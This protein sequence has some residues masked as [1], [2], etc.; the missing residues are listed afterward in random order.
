[1]MLTERGR[2]L[3]RDVKLSRGEREGEIPLS[4]WRKEP[5]K[6]IKMWCISI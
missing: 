6:K 4:D 2:K 3:E 5:N 1:M